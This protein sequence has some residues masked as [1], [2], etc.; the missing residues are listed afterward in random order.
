MFDNDA[1]GCFNWI[2]VALAMIA[3]LRLGMLRPAAQMHSSA[4]LTSYEVLCE[5]GSWSF[6]SILS[7]SM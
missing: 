4:L 7:S 1:T 2:I 3:A 6:R 5:D